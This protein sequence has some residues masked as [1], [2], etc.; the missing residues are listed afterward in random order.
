MIDTHTFGLGWQRDLPDY[1]DYTPEN[2][3]VKD[4][5]EH[6]APLDKAMSA[7]SFGKADLR[8]WCSPIENQGSLGS[9]TAHAAIG[10][11][12]YYQRRTKNEYLDASRLFLYKVT[13]NLLE[14]TGDTGAYLRS[15]MSALVLFGVPPER[16]YPYT[17]ANF[18]KEPPPFCYAFAQ[19]YKAIKYF[20]LDP[21]GSKPNAVLTLVKRY[22]MAGLP[23][24][25]GFS[26]YTSIPPVGEGKGEIP[27]PI[28]GDS[29]IGGH[30]VL[31]VGFDD[32]KKIGKDKGALLIRNSWGKEW[33]EQ[34][35]GW[36]PY[37]YVEAGLAV[38]IWSMVDA[39]FV[40]S[41]IFE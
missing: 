10:M 18:D 25:F 1:R 22:L 19:N 32:Q 23:S 33:G 39:G 31:A 29:L 37:A 28:D 35:Y 8:E 2:E 20:R 15:T 7:R 34:G 26:V 11:V 12:E 6:S 21:P 16:Y 9:C 41:S 14:W 4:I 17:I 38:D 3:K 24:M 30:A 13:R 5:L 40:S 27:F 36:L